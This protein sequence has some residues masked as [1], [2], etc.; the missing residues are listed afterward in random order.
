MLPEDGSP[1]SDNSA[2]ADTRLE[3]LLPAGQLVLTEL[4]GC[5]VIDPVYP[6]SYNHGDD[7]LSAFSSSPLEAAAEIY[8]DPR[9]AQLEAKDYVF[10]DTETTGLFGAGTL[11]FM[12]GVAFLEDG[13]LVVRQYFMRDHADEPSMLLQLA[14]LL[15]SRSGIVTFNGRSFDLPLLETRYFL[16]RMDD[17]I[18]AI[19]QRPHMDLLHPSRRLWR[20]R[21]GSCSLGSLEKNLMSITRT[22]EDVPGWAIPGIYMDYL[23]I[24]DAQDIARVFYH[25]HIDM[26]SMVVLASKIVRLFSSPTEKDHPLDI[27]SLARWQVALRNLQSAESNLKLAL[28]GRGRFGLLLEDG[29]AIRQDLGYLLRRTERRDEAAHQWLKIA[30]KEAREPQ[31]RIVLGAHIELAK[32]YEWHQVDLE[33]ARDWTIRA[34]TLVEQMDPKLAHEIPAISHRLQRLDRKLDS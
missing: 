5:F 6:L 22:G 8:K 17:Q 33:K 16:N 26:L 29:L 18:G 31:A 24:R 15:N 11:A 27:Y 1:H 25:N 30:E 19:N 10:L 4:G 20:K 13:A 7:I 28:E 23:R 9:L 3:Q 2:G 34:Q 14:E 12:V 32:H 21:L